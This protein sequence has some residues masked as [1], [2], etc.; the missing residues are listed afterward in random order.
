[1]K[2][3]ISIPVW[4]DEHLPAFERNGVP[5]LLRAKKTANLDRSDVRAIVHADKGFYIGDLNVDWR[6]IPLGVNS[7]CRVGNAA[8]LAIEQAEPGEAVM[9]L[10]AEMILG[11]DI[12]AICEQHFAADRKL[13]VSPS[14]RKHEFSNDCIWGRGRVAV[15]PYVFFEDA[16]SAVMHAFDLHP[17]AFLKDRDMAFTG[18]T[19]S[20]II[21]MFRKS[22][23]A[24]GPV[25]KEQPIGLDYRRLDRP[26]G[27]RD[28]LNAAK[29]FFFLKN[30]HW[31]FRQQ[32]V[33]RGK[34][35]PRAKAIADR[36]M[37]RAEHEIRIGHEVNWWARDVARAILPRPVRQQ[38]LRW[39]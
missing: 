7:A 23:I 11:P 19:P 12:F 20:E 28:V 8:R 39:V 27:C 33:L 2:W 5:A 6:S 25:I 4:G 15:P 16:E 14:I 38:I 30:Q 18:P 29:H 22:E 36:M 17:I 31:L 34:P 13:I 26:F 1:M 37:D 21:S 32:I 9:L 35:D 10:H 24:I 3:L